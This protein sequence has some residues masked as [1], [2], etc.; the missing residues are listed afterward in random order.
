MITTEL[1]NEQY[2]AKPGFSSSVLKTFIS[3]SPKAAWERYIRPDRPKEHP[4]R[5]M[6]LGTMVHTLVLEPENFERDFPPDGELPMTNTGRMR[7][8]N[9]DETLAKAKRVAEAVKSHPMARGVLYPSNAVYESSFFENCP[10]TG[11][12]LKCRPDALVPEQWAVDLKTTSTGLTTSFLYQARSLGYH[13]QESFYRYVLECCG[14][15]VA[16]FFFVVVETVPPHDVVVYE[17]DSSI[18]SEASMQVADALERIATLQKS[19]AEWPGISPSNI[20]PLRW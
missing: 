14:A 8:K 11:L 19:E 5:A 13:L 6:L 2:H 16:R 9:W 4:S 15:H 20:L 12:K 7:K 10:K 17:L 18:L 1:T 3:Q